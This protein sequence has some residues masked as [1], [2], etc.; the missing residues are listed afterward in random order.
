VKIKSIKDFAS[1]TG[2]AEKVVAVE[3]GKEG[4][5]E[6]T[7]LDAKEAP[8]S[9]SPDFPAYYIE[10]LVDSSRGRN[11]YAV[12]ASVIDEKLYVVTAQTKED[13]YARLKQTASDLLDSF[14]VATAAG[15][16]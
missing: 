10:Y 13:D 6:A 9:P 3:R 5:F 12:K 1:P 16:K 7:V 15:E 8:K 11:H 14:S 4:V 2:L